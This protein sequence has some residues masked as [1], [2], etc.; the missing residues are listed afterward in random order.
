[1]RSCILPALRLGTCAVA[2]A[3]VLSG[4]A[5]RTFAAV[6]SAPRRAEAVIRSWPAASQEAARAMIERYGRPD[7]V[8][9][10]M[11]VWYDRGL[12]NRVIVYR[13][14]ERDEFPVPHIDYVE[15]TV[16]YP[17]PPHKVADLLRF[18]RAIVVDSVH[19]TLSAQGASEAENTLALNLADEIMRGKRSVS[20]AQSF[21]KETVAREAAGKSSPYMERL[22]FTPLRKKEASPTGIRPTMEA[23]PRDESA[24]QWPQP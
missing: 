24:P 15:N 20:S 21:L 18:D 3:A 10:R 22:L 2:C 16:N 4:P 7:G 8:L 13:I 11:L 1:M 5:R 17:V 14:E 12:W 6:V 9:D 19:G 23:Q